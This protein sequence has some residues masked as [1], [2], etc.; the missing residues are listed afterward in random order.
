MD[1]EIFEQ[2]ARDFAMIRFL[3]WAENDDQK[4]VKTTVSSIRRIRLVMEKEPQAQVY[5]VLIYC[6]DTLF[7]IMEEGNREKIAAF[8]DAVHNMPDLGT[9][10]HNLRSLKYELKDFR[11]KYGKHFFPFFE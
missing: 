7:E 5:Q 11:K 9:G 4:S 1:K 8:A 6:I 10:K 3:Y 2:L